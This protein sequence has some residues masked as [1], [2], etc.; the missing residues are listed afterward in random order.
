MRGPTIKSKVLEYLA[1]GPATVQEMAA[2]IQR[3]ENV[4][5]QV[6]LELRELG[7][8]SCARRVRNGV[9]GQPPRLWKICE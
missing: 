3:K 2:E 8:L 5:R 4:V 7:V 1:D 9:R 6:C